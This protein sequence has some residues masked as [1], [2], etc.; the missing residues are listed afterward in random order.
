M[1]LHFIKINGLPTL[2][3]KKNP[4]YFCK[5]KSLEDYRQNVNSDYF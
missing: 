5:E 1:K 4:L 2:V 3:R